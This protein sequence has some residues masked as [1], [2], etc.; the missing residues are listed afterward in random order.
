MATTRWTHAPDSPSPNFSARACSSTRPVAALAALDGWTAAA[1]MPSM[2]RRWPRMRATTRSCRSTARDRREGGKKTRRHAAPRQAVR[3][4]CGSGD[5]RRGRP[6]RRDERGR[7]GLPGAMA[8]M[9]VAPHG[10]FLDIGPAHYVREVHRQGAGAA[11][12]RAPRRGDPEHGRGPGRRRSGRAGHGA[13]AAAER[14][15]RPRGACG[16]GIRRAVRARRRGGAAC[17]R[18]VPVVTS[19]S[20]WTSAARAEGV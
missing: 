12:R 15:V 8:V 2:R 6:G 7:R 17:G 18:S 20:S 11:T 19:I 3:R 16:G 14:P 13:G 10:A 1:A 5:G 4:R 9:A